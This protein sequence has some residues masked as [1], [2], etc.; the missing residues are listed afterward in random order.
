MGMMKLAYINFKS[1]YKNYLSLVLSL[2]FTI[3]VFLNFQNILASDAYEGLGTR[4]KEYIDMLVQM[5]SFV[6]GCFMVFFIWYSTNVFLTRR[7]REIGVYVFM[8]L[9]NQ[10]I[11]KLYLIEIT[12]IGLLALSLGLVLGMMTSGL[13]QMILGA[14]SKLTVPIRFGTSPRPVAVTSAVY[15][16]IYLIFAWKGYIN[17]VQSSVLGM[18]S[19]AKQ[20]EYVRQKKSV[21]FV[22]AAL[23]MAVLGSGYFMAV[24]EGRNVI[25]DSLKAVVLV[26]VGVYLLFGGMI[27]LLFQT[28]AGNKRLLYQKTRVLWMNRVIFRMKKNYRTYAI[29]SILMLCSVTALA[30]GFAMKG[31]YE[32]IVQF[33]NTYTFQL[34]SNQRDLDSRAREL[35]ETENE[36]V[37]STQIPILGLDKSLIQSK[38]A[39][40]RY[41]LI[42]Y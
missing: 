10:K 14:V 38:E 20:N 33:E 26:T 2:A 28:L 7:K 12:L 6:L 30:M 37:L 39:Y 15:L 34:L 41:A 9:S 22:K 19:A 8:G 24:R 23:G 16:I 5:T 36:I 42:P 35:I 25:S 31:R 18:I 32:T 3:L 29:V 21:L 11:G 17:I 13:F 27:P 40:G 1:S 4:N